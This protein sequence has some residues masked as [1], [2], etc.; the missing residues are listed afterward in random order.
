MI[1]EGLE[2]LE[3][4]LRDY[5]GALNEIKMGLRSNIP[6]K[7]E[8]LVFYERCR[9]LGL[10]LVAGGVLDQPYI[11]LQELAIVIEQ[12]DLFTILENRSQQQDSD[13]L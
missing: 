6:D 10:P 4:A 9:V 8:A 3:T 13:A 5:Y 11:W 7:P 2:R 12:V 1:S